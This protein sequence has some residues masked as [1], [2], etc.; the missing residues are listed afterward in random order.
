MNTRR[1]AKTTVCVAVTIAALILSLT[2]TIR[3]RTVHTCVLCRVER[4]EHELLKQQWRTVDNTAVTSW[5]NQN[6]PAHAHVWSRL[7]CT[8]G[9][10]VFGGT[11]FWGCGSR[12]PICDIPPDME[13]GFIDSADDTQVNAFFSALTSTDPNAQQNAID[14]VWHSVLGR[15]G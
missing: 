6:M 5:Y 10:N 2:L 1:F 3:T 11:T 12:H 15:G 8:R 4:T 14:T 7:S 13:L 9:F